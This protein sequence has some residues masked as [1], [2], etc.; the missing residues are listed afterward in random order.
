[1]KVTST[2]TGKP[3]LA[4]QR[5]APSS[6][7]HLLICLASLPVCINFLLA[8][9]RRPPFLSARRPPFLSA[10]ALTLMHICHCRLLFLFTI[11]LAAGTAVALALYT[12]AF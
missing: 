8:P 10:R 3:P 9:A 11:G 1:M 12:P 4:G 5:G 7:G 2:P 6:A